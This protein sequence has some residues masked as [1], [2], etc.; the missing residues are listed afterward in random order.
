MFSYERTRVQSQGVLHATPEE[1]K[2]TRAGRVYKV[3]Y[4]PHS[5]H[6]MSSYYLLFYCPPVLAFCRFGGAVE[7][8]FHPANDKSMW[9][10]RSRGLSSMVTNEFCIGVVI[11]LLKSIISTWQTTKEQIGAHTSY[12]RIF[13][14]I[15]SDRFSA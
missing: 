5:F 14:L 7:E 8:G 9:A 11:I 4:S 6:F 1:R 3:R 10:E 12:A 13:I 15:L 2:A